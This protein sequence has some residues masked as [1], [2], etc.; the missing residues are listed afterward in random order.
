VDEPL[1]VDPE[2][3]AEILSGA[4]VPV[5]VDFW[6]AWCGPCRSAAPHVKN[7][8]KQMKGRAVVVKVDTDKHGE[9]AARF[10][11]RGIPNFVVLKDGRPVMQ[12]AGAVDAGTMAQWLSSAGA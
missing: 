6:A 4:K 10:G 11:V 8:A 3:F 1:D 9:L 12:Q 5:L 7:V 2:G